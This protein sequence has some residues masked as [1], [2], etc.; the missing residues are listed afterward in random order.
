MTVD[1]LNLTIEAYIHTTKESLKLN[2][3]GSFYSAYF[4]LKGQKKLSGKDLDDVLTRIDGNS[5]QMTDED[6]FKVLKS[7]CEEVD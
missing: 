7:L 4:Y 2:I 3:T 1:E 6:M 5:Q